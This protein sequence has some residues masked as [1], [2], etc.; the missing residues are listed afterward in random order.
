MKSKGFK[1]ICNKCGNVVDVKD[2]TS[3]VDYLE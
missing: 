1:I 2:D 3:N